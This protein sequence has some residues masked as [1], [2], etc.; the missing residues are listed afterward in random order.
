V[1]EMLALVQALGVRASID[2]HITP[3][4]DGTREPMDLRLDRETLKDVYTG[5]LSFLLDPPDC[6]PEREVQCACAR[7]VVA[8]AA[9]GDVYPCIGAPIPSGNVREKSFEEIWRTSAELKRIRALELADFRAC[10]PCP[11]RGYCRRTSGFVYTTTGEYTGPEEWTCMEASVLHE[12]H[13]ESRRQ[14]FQTYGEDSPQ[15]TQRTQSEEPPRA[16][17]TPR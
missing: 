5:P 4:Y 16:L 17:R 2:P 11:D 3:R 15:R 6:R 12:I 9:N 1:D 8:I 7:S 14:A 13:D 10:E